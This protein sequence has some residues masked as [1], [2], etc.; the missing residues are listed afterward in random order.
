MSRSFD[1]PFPKLVHFRSATGSPAEVPVT[2]PLSGPT[3]A[4]LK[5]IGF[6]DLPRPTELRQLV[7]N[8]Y[9]DALGDAV[10][11]FSGVTFPVIVGSEG[12][13]LKVP[14][15]VGAGIREWKASIRYSGTS[16]DVKTAWSLT[17]QLE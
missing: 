4:I 1:A 7:L 6:V 3:T 15:P 16:D 8:V 14:I 12:R 9:I 5:Q 11:G 10:E 2:L 13:E 17:L